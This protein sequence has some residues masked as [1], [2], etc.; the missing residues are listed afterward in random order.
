MRFLG[1]GAER[2]SAA[3]SA[4]RR[5][6][7]V[8]GLRAVAILLVVAFHAGLPL[9][10][11][12]TGVDVF[13]VISGFVI[14]GL[15][16][17]ELETR[18]TISL[19]RFYQRRIKRLLPA[20]ALMLL[21]VTLLG[22][23]FTPT[24]SQALEARTAIWASLFVANF[25]LY[26]APSGYF[27][28]AV[29]TNPLL[30]T[31][32][33]A[34]E[35]QFYLVFPALLLG[36]WWFARR[37]GRSGR[38]TAFAALALVT[39]LSFLFSLALSRGHPLAG[40]HSPGSFAFYSSPTR[41][42]EFGVGGLLS[43]AAVRLSR[44]PRSLATAAGVAGAFALVAGAI[45]IH[46]SGFPG[47]QALIPVVGTALLIAAGVATAT[48]VP[49]LLS[50]RPAVWIGDRSYSWYLWHWP[51]IV[52]ANAQWPAQGGVAAAAAIVSLVPAC[53]SYRL[54]ENPIRFS[55]AFGL[56]ALGVTA[57][58]CVAAPFFG[59]AFLFRA[60][61][62]LVTS[63]NDVLAQWVRSQRPHADAVRGCDN[64]TPLGE[65]RGGRCR[66]AVPDPKGTVV[67]LGDS[68]AGHFTEPVTAAA[69]RQ[70]YDALVAT[71]DGCP[72]VD[73]W[74]D[75][76]A[77]SPETC[78]TFRSRTLEALVRLRPSLVILAARTDSAVE[79][80]VEFRDP[81]TGRIT[82]EPEAK[83]RLWRNGLIRVARRL[84]G[85]GIPVLVVH[86]VPAIPNLPTACSTASVL[87]GACSGSVSRESADRRRRR[88]IDAEAAAVA[89]VPATW[90]VDF[91]DA[92]CGSTTCSAARQGTR[93][94]R[95]SDHLSVDG[96]LSLT[97]AFEDAVRAHAL[98]R[99]D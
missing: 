83:A 99:S 20:L 93:L 72:F 57:A 22:S 77:T 66:W 75:G 26:S 15:L 7:D 58:V 49:R 63:S 52:F 27:D 86:P 90:S 91:V 35:E 67:L 76:L 21:C 33:L 24:E 78:R 12:F 6:L 61:D 14:C 42:W 96:A 95:N 55:R 13:F 85:A 39:A 19:P 46:E 32:T 4:S 2:G 10:G 97:G 59:A 80:D 31:W 65:R 36:A 11:G 60:H 3:A 82:S 28:P 37:G 43:L 41:A 17:S 44:L 68:N 18:G 92:L 38:V 16:V 48:G 50:S 74:I 40:V 51:L 89:A 94:Y 56:R 79:S 62:A 54:V 34:A 88:S 47:L 73:V 87:S 9:P 45:W 8:Q 71:F 29:T 5:R 53:I 64:A 84:N 69:E 98:P 23:V 30:H 25:Y 1:A 70:G 81:P